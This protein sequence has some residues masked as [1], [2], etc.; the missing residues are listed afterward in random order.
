MPAPA[1][2]A[3]PETCLSGPLG[4]KVRVGVL[5]N[6]TR[7][8]AWEHEMLRQ[9]V[10]SDY[11]QIELVVLRGAPRTKRM[12]LKTRAWSKFDRMLFH[13][14]CR[15]ENHRSV[16]SVDAFEPCECNGLL[17][18][19]QVMEVSP[20][21]TGSFE[22]FSDEDVAKI[23]AL[24]LDVIIRLGFGILR[25]KI[26]QA[27]RYG[28]WS[29][30][31]GDSQ[32]NRG[33]P[34][35]FW[36]VFQNSP[37]IGSTLQVLNDTLDGGKVLF[38]SYA[39]TDVLS[40]RRNCNSY[41]WKTMSFIPRKLKEL[42]DLGAFEFL[43]RVEEINRHPQF[44]CRRIY[45]PPGNREFLALATRL[46]GRYVREKVRDAISTEQWI[47]MFGMGEGITES[48][49]RYKRIVPPKDRSWADPQVIYRDGM[50]HVFVE[51][52]PHDTQCGHISLLTVDPDG[53]WGEAQPIIKQP[54]HMSYPFIFQWQGRYFMVPETRANQ[55]ISLY[56]CVEFP[57]RWE[58]RYHLMEG[59]SALD[60]TLHFHDDRWWLFATMATHAGGPTSDELF[61]FYSDSPISRVWRP[62]AANPVIS[63]AR[64]SRPAGRLFCYRGNLYR[65][66]QD[67]S[68][69]YGF[70]I[71]INH[72]QELSES[73]YQEQPVQF[74]TPSADD[75]K[76]TG[77]H[78]FTYEHRM[79]MIDARV[80]RSKFV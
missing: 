7:M 78:T 4:R 56:E 18:P 17:K 72:V 25:G 73:V 38:R 1:V 20:E 2:A 11:A 16:G 10:E 44:Y 21:C 30:H 43:R 26:L 15:V 69:N 14:Y 37:V 6:S 52:L 54:Y 55:T 5:L 40:V 29:Y 64:R 49:S 36:E 23:K 74:I 9:I 24:D 27:A 42:H 77:Y 13:L 75:R 71:N 47:L 66:S 67:C 60:S 68:R 3:C 8:R 61:L 22:R 28:V 79:T 59:V 33:G 62:H 65:P 63:D 41:Y 57:H 45:K 50:Y 76:T 48:L 12:P 35:G 46:A 32:S 19:A 31:H 34:P 53:R 80:I 39:G 70:A 51:E 58:F